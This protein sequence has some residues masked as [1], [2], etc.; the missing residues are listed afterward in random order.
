MAL[1]LADDTVAVKVT[2]CPYVDGLEEEV[3]VVVVATF[4][5]VTATLG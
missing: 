4:E 5:G 2:D 1:P 3:T